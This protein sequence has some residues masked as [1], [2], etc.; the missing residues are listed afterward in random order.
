MDCMRQLVPDWVE[1]ASEP[2]EVSV[3]DVGMYRVYHWVAPEN[4]I[5]VSIIAFMS[6]V[7]FSSNS[8][9]SPLSFTSVMM[10]SLII[11]VR[12]SF[13]TYSGLAVIHVRELLCKKN[14]IV[15]GQ[16]GLLSTWSR[17]W[18]LGAIFIFDGLGSATTM[19][20]CWSFI[21]IK[22]YT[23]LM[24]FRR[25]PTRTLRFLQFYANFSLPDFYAPHYELS[26]WRL[27]LI[28]KT[29]LL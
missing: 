1:Y 14:I 27:L 21:T 23:F 3:E 15:V 17:S 22:Y 25:R 28:A 10:F 16:I 12:C 9:P 7:R 19:W 8:T 20:F 29:I 18:P 11:C 13:C 5:L 24:I 26:L 6:A 2:S 4:C